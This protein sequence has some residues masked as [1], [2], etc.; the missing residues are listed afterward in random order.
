MKTFLDNQ[1][2]RSFVQ[3]KIKKVNESNTAVEIG[4]IIRKLNKFIKKNSLKVSK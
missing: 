3:T 2:F 1:T 4:Y